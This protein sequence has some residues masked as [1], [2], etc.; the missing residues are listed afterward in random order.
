MKKVSKRKID[1]DNKLISRVREVITD[2]T[3][4]EMLFLSIAVTKDVL[5]VDVATSAFDNVPVYR[6]FEILSFLF[7]TQGKDV[8]EKYTLIFYPLDSSEYTWVR[9]SPSA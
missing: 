7:E 4:W 8:V 2:N 5:Y 3:A 9:G 1:K 6:R